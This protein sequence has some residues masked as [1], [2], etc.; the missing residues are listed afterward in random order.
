LPWKDCCFY[1]FLKLAVF[2]TLVFSATFV[3]LVYLMATP[4]VC[5][6]IVLNLGSFAFVDLSKEL[7]RGPS[8]LI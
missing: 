8:L 7:G 4:L 2:S 6:K 5:N 1:L 3:V